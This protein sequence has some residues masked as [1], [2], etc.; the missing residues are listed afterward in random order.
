ML[1]HQLVLLPNGDVTI[2]CADLNSKGVIGNITTNSLYDIYTKP[3]RLQM[4]YEFI[5]GK[6][7]E[8]DLCKECETF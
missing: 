4:L 6:K 1:M 8:I 7:N 3:Q 2:C 5:K